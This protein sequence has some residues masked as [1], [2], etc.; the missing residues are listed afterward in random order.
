[1]KHDFPRLDA[2]LGRPSFWLHIAV[3]VETFHVFELHQRHWPE[4]A[5]HGLAE[6]PSGV[7]HF[8]TVSGTG[9]VAELTLL[10]AMF[11]MNEVVD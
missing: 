2:A 9:K 3:L 10:A 6:T 7:A 1:L 5:T 8:R 11:V 4:F